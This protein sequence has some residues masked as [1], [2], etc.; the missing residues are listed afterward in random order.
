MDEGITFKSPLIALNI[1]WIFAFLYFIKKFY[2]P[3]KSLVFSSYRIRLK[4]RAKFIGEP[5]TA[6]FLIRA[7]AISFIVIAIARPQR[8]SKYQQIASSGVDMMLA[9]DIS[10]SMT[11]SDFSINMTKRVSR[12]DAAKSV[13]ADF[14]NKRKHDRIG[15]VAFSRFPYIVSPLTLNYEWLLKNLDRL[16]AGIIED[17]TAIGSAVMT[18]VNRLKDLDAKSRVVVLLTDGVNNYGDVSPLMAAEV[19]EN[20]KAKIYT[21]MVGNDQFFPVDEDTLRQM[22]EKTGGKF[23]KAYDLKTLLG[24]YAEIDSIEKSTVSLEGF[25]S[26]EDF[27]MPFLILA[28]ALLLL[29]RFL[30]NTK[31]RTIP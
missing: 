9:I 3:D 25:S 24:I 17:G 13:V 4:G 8:Y 22:A 21:I 29:E 1:I 15:L 20:F 27:F 11:I 5:G 6:Q 19:A 16:Q 14:I 7:L 28:L 2:C 26:C 30:A 12:I 18:C 31:Y 10:S 23:Y